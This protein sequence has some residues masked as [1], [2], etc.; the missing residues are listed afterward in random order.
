MHEFAAL[1]VMPAGQRSIL[2]L[3][4]LYT[5][6]IA[7]L[8]SQGYSEEEA[9]Q[10]VVQDTSDKASSRHGVLADPLFQSSFDRLG[11]LA[12]E[13]YRLIMETRPE[14]F[15]DAPCNCA[16]CRAGREAAQL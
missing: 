10:M 2:V 15:T 1:A 9:R 5:L 14:T 6:E 3:L 16:K 4:G 8:V 13:L 12:G 7:Q 11:D